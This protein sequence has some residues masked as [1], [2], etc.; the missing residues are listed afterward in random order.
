MAVEERGAGLGRI[1]MQ[2]VR[3]ASAAGLLPA[4]E[5]SVEPGSVVPTDG[6]LGH[7]PLEKEG[8]RHHIVF[9]QR[10]PRAGVRIAAA[11]AQSDL[12]AQAPAAGHAPRC[13]QPRASGLLSGRTAIWTSSCFG[14]TGA[15]HAAGGNFSTAWFN[16]RSPWSRRPTARSSPTGGPRPREPNHTYWGHL[17]ERNVLCLC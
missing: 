9:T 3:N 5:E 15:A 2:R 12:A 10:P 8:Y 6:R 16:K 7:E 11:G 1:R 4:V 17:K 14:S 13:G